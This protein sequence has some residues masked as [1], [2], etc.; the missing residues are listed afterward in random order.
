MTTE[1]LLEGANTYTSLA[2]VASGPEIDVPEISPA[3]ISILSISW[4]TS[5]AVTN[6]LEC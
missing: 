1:L 6:A 2:E 3:T 5:I 4:A